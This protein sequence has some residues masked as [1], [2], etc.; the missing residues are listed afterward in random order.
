MTGLS[1]PI[2]WMKNGDHNQ[3][4]QNAGYTRQQRQLALEERGV[5][6][7]FGQV[8]VVDTDQIGV[9]VKSWQDCTHDVYVRSYNG[10]RTYPEGDIKA[11]V[12]NKELP[13]GEINFYN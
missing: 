3:D 5:T 10:V 11:L 6:F 4:C 13:E 12:Y 2:C 1:C 9:I 8:V 7:Q